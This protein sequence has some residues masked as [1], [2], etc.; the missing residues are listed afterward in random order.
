MTPRKASVGQLHKQQL[1][2]TEDDIF[3]DLDQ[4]IFMIDLMEDT[5]LETGMFV[6]LDNVE[7]MRLFLNIRNNVHFRHDLLY[8]TRR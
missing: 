1:R 6:P 2:Q 7:M 8:A 5:Q 3:N 4:M